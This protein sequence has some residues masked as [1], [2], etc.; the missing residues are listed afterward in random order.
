MSRISQ[1]QLA[2]LFG[3]L[4][5]SYTAGIDLRTIL[6]RESETGSTAYR[7]KT[8]KVAQSVADGH[9]LA[10]SMKQTGNYFPELAVS[11]VEA[12]ERGGRMEDSFNRLATHYE[13]LVSF[14]NKLLTAL[15]W[16]AFELFAAIMLVGLMMAIGDGIYRALEFEPINWLGMGS[17]VGNVIAY[18]VLITLLLIGVV[19]LVVGTAKGWFGSLPMKIARRI[20]L[21]GKTIQSLALSRFAWTMSVA[22]NAGMNP[23][24][25]AR[26]SLRSTE[27][28]YYK[29]QEKTICR[30]LQQG[31]TFYQT[32]KST[33][34]FPEDLLIYVDNGE[35]AGEL[36]ESMDRASREYQKTA[37]LNLK[38]IGTVGF[39][40][41]LLFVGFVVLVIAVT[42]V[43]AYTNLLNNMMQ[44]GWNTLGR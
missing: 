19:V 22:E 13:N 28:Y 4:A 10:E 42:A 27:N 43:S 5:T 18:F 32:F 16:P 2:K 36:A 20:P 7:L 34:V 26:L 24:E 33:G 9:T 8:A 14:R 25:T 11:V 35:T 3:R 38:L 40:L 12:G 31:Q 1:T 23:V 29:Q 39:V 6:K 15:A 30:A 17:T 37:D 41:M 21:I 44:P